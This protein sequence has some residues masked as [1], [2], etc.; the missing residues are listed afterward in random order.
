MHRIFNYLINN[1]REPFM[2]YIL[3][4]SLLALIDIIYIVFF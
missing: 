4:W 3:L 1:I 2:L